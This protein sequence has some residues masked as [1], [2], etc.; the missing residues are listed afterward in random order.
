MEQ[1]CH[2]LPHLEQV[3]QVLEEVGLVWQ[4][5]D[6]VQ[7]LQQ[8]AQGHG[9]G[10]LDTRRVAFGTGVAGA[11]TMAVPGTGVGGAATLGVPG[12]S[13]TLDVGKTGADAGNGGGCT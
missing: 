2:V 5:L 7:L 11:A 10:A 12:A 1:V 4:V 13:D 6:K 3:W 9:A 8:M